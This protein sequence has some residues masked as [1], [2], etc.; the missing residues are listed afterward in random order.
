MS[1][2]LVA[3]GVAVGVALVG[4]GS[5][6]DLLETRPRATWTLFVALA[7]QASLDTF[8]RPETTG[9]TTGGSGLGYALLVTS[10]G[11]LVVFCIAN[12]NLRG[13]SV[14]AIGIALNGMVVTANHGMPVRADGV[15]TTIKHHTERPSDR[16]TFLGD[17]IVV[18]PLNQALSFGDLILAVGLADVLVHR[19]RGAVFRT[20]RRRRRAASQFGRDTEA[21]AVS[22]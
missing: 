3:A 11:L 2:F 20:R 9:A 13:M 15:R 1:F 16:M 6:R 22:A 8:W 21:A 7:I 12:L 14:V 17:I 4:G 5:L 19:S 18:D 10:Y